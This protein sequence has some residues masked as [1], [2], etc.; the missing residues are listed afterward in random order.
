MPDI[1]ME[2][3]VSRL[4]RSHDHDR[5]CRDQRNKILPQVAT[6]GEADSGGFSNQ[7]IQM[8]AMAEL[9]RLPDGS[10]MKNSQETG[11]VR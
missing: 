7:R 9:N 5:E 10:R 4:S 2:S 8:S 3:V 11:S 1:D 6:A